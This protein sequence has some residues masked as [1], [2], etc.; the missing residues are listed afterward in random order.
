V[1]IKS[2]ILISVLLISL[3]FSAKS[4]AEPLGEAGLDTG[5]TFENGVAAVAQ[6]GDW[7]YL[8]GKTGEFVRVSIASGQIDPEWG[9]RQPT[10]FKQNP[11]ATRIFQSADSYQ[12]TDLL[13]DH[14]GR[15][16]VYGIIGEGLVSNRPL[17]FRLKSNGQVDESFADHGLKMRTD[18]D[19]GYNIHGKL[20]GE[21]TSDALGNIYLIA[22][23]Y[24]SPNRNK[25]PVSWHYVEKLSPKGKLLKRILVRKDTSNRQYF[26]LTDIETTKMTGRVYLSARINKET[27]K[28]ISLTGRGKIDRNFASKSKWAAVKST[29]SSHPLGVELSEGGY[30]IFAAH[31]LNK[32]GTEEMIV[33][34]LEP[35]GKRY[36]RF[37][38][39]GKLK[40]TAAWLKEQTQGKTLITGFNFAVNGSLITDYNS[41]TTISITGVRRY[42]QQYWD[43]VTFRIGEFG[44]KI[45]QPET[46]LVTYGNVV[47][48]SGKIPL[49]VYRGPVQQDKYP[50]AV[51]GG[52]PDKQTR[53]QEVFL[54]RLFD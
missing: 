1:Q 34:K 49:A 26:N 9:L 41:Q 14:Q 18:I 44:Q 20:A 33:E 46:T 50:V 36:T 10:V 40:I 39:K 54:Y 24:L 7:I 8:A 5:K 15:I 37:G 3:S 28:L 47:P 31:V 52:S 17:I 38:Q 19:Y 29:D 16:L 32:T 53:K 11:K 12:I 42:S 6:K 30:P 22:T 45:V 48:E 35:S 25:G 21:M 43:T 27:S 51:I 23:K 13:I 2:I 4:Q